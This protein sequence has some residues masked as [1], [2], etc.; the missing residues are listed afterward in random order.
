MRS[1]KRF[2]EGYHPGTPM[3]QRKTRLIDC[4]RNHHQIPCMGALITD[5][6][7][8]THRLL[9]GAKQRD[10]IAPFI[11]GMAAAHS[12]PL[13]GHGCS[14]SR[15]YR[16]LSLSCWSR[17]V[18]TRWP[19]DWLGDLRFSSTGNWVECSDPVPS[20]WVWQGL[21]QMQQKPCHRITAPRS[22]CLCPMQVVG[23]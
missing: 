10:E 5:I 9:H 4:I 18:Q 1:R 8:G 22:V 3:I 11:H 21:T 20:S 19:T 7:H 14:N 2:R 13:D 23:Q 17:F 16:W 15:P 6:I 12:C